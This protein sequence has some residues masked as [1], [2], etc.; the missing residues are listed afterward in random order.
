MKKRLLTL[1]FFAVLILLIIIAVAPASSWGLATGDGTW[2]WVNP[3]VQGNTMRSVSFIDANTGWA[4]GDAGTVLKTTDGG[5]SWIAR[6]PSPNSCAG[7]SPYGNGCNLKGISFIDAS[8]GWAAGAYG[9]IWKTINGGT[10]WTA[11][12]LPGGTG[13]GG[14]SCVYAALHGI[15]FI[16]STV[17]IAVGPSYAF[18]TRDGGASWLQITGIS[19]GHSLNAVQMVDGNTGFAVGDT[20]AVYKITWNVSA[21]A[22]APQTGDG[23]QSLTGLYFA[24]AT[25]GFAVGGGRLWRTV[26]GGTTWLKNETPRPENFRAVTMT[27][28][29]LVVTGG[30]EVFGENAGGSVILKRTATTNWT[31]SVDTVATG[32]SAAASTGTTDQLL[33]VVFP[34][35]SSTGFAAGEAGGI[36]K[37]TDTGGSWTLQAGGNGKRFTDSSFINDTTGWMVAMDGSVIKTTNAGGS[38]TGDASG[39]AAGTKLRGVSF[40]DASTGFAVGYS[41]LLGNGTNAG[42]AYKYVSGTWSAMTV[43]AGV[44]TLEAI[45]MTSAT[46]GWAVGRA[47]GDT[48]A[49]V[50]LKTTDGS[51]WVFDSSGFSGNIR[52]YGV[53]ATSASNGWAVGENVTLGKSVLLKYS[54]GAPGSWAVMEK[55]DSTGFL[56]IDMVDGSTGYAVGYKSPSATPGYWLDSRIYKTVDGGATWNSSLSTTMHRWL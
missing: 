27:G 52:L 11:Q 20:G 16:N 14:G 21:W 22:A 25:N 38:W 49:G 10:S 33:A 5:A 40:L 46:S 35:G 8:T 51:N 41:G 42:V 24:N 2:Q 18:A 53:D 43:P 26:N 34:G 30:T 36:V 4:A 9:T 3:S 39:I 17:G 6:I 29:T 15:H 19:T 45:H 31:D 7:V 32:L 28:N 23:T 47:P 55:T 56:S 13:C 12:S 48:G 54:A 37:T 44:A 50:A 1:Q